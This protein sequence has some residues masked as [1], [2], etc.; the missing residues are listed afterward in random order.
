MIPYY[1]TSETSLTAVNIASDTATSKPFAANRDISREK[2]ELNNVKGE[3][4]GVKGEP[5]GTKGNLSG[6]FY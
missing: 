6:H 3:L 5:I 4:I 2:G 1:F